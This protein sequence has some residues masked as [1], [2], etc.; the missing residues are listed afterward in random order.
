MG[1]TFRRNEGRR[2]KWDK[3]GNKSHKLRELE[4]DKFKHRP[5]LIPSP[6]TFDPPDPDI[7]EL[8]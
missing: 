6:Q 5:A 3:R 4:D 2:P 7:S 8:P 1:K